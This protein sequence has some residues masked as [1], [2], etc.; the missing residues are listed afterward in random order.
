M[1]TMWRAIFI[2]PFTMHPMHSAMIQLRL[3]TRVIEIVY[4]IK[5][6]AY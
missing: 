1:M 3:Q 4:V 5:T 2:L 6:I